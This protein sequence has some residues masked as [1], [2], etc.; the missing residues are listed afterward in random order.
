MLI[1]CPECGKEISDKSKQCIHCGYPLEESK[2]KEDNKNTSDFCIIEG[3][4][5]DM[6]NIVKELNINS[7]P[8]SIDKMRTI[9]NIKTR[10][11]L[12]FE[13]ANIIYNKVLNYKQKNNLFSKSN[14][15][16]DT[17]NGKQYNLTVIAKNL[18]PISRNSDKILNIKIVREKYNVSLD[19]AN[20]ICNSIYANNIIIANNTISCPYCKSIDTVKISTT[21]KTINTA[22]FGILGKK[23][24]YQWHCNTCGS[25]F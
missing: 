17:V 3:I 5:Y 19:T 24:H 4:S 14:D 20:K 2:I 10:Y 9:Q 11:N 12:P 8:N 16:F 7:N 6:S 21:S 1:K 18:K 25:N 22:M 13:T 15:I 23:R